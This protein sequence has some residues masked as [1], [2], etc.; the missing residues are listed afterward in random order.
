LPN[1]PRLRKS[2]FNIAVHIRWGVGDMAIQNGEKCSRQIDL[3]YFVSLLER[4]LLEIDLP[5]VKITIFTDAPSDDLEYTPLSGQETLWENSKSFHGGVMSVIGL[6]LSKR[7]SSLGIEPRILRG[8]DPLSVIQEMANS[9]ILIM[10]RSSFSYV[11]GILNASQ[12]VYNP[13]TFWHKPLTN[14]HIMRD[15]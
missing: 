4:I 5:E 3:S 1:F 7:F 11:A 14:W 10:S 12:N 8:G 15:I 9:D 2:G 6:D 13:S